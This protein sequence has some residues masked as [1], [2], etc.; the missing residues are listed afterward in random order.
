LEPLFIENGLKEP[1]ILR[2]EVWQI[3]A[4]LPGKGPIELAYKVALNDSLFV[5]MTSSYISITSG[6]AT[7][8]GYPHLFFASHSS[9]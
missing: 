1:M 3:S 5:E 7:Y 9:R 4:K 8:R 6:N 2:L